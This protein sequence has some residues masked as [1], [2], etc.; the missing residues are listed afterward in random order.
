MIHHLSKP[1]ALL[2]VLLGLATAALAEPVTYAGKIGQTDI[3]VEFTSDPSSPDGP[4]AG[5]YF[6]RSKGVD[7]PLQA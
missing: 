4:L 2:G 3:V 1:V 6:Y 7:I 5:R